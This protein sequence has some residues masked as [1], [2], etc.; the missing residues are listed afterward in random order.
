MDQLFGSSPSVSNNSYS[1]LS[2][3]QSNLQG[4]MAHLFGQYIPSF[5]SQFTSGQN[6]L[7]YG[8]S[9]AAPLTPTQNSLISQITGAVQ[10][11]GSAN[12]PL[13]MASG[14]L[15]HLLS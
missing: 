3:A 12:A 2:P 8:G 14:T 7:A 4:T 1:E 11:G 10:P 15:Q 13:N 9:Y 6:P 5:M